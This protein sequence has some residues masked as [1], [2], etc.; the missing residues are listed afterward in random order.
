MN[1]FKV[2]LKDNSGQECSVEDIRIF[3]KHL[4]LFHSRGVTVHDENG[5]YFTVDDEFRNKIDQLV[6]KMSE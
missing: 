6:D 3:Q 4:R 5:H 2:T 1:D